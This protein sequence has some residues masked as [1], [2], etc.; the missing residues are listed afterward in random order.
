[1]ARGWWFT[2]SRYPVPW[3]G[4]GGLPLIPLYGVGGL[5]IYYAINHWRR[6]PLLVFLSGF[7]ILTLLELGVSYW[8]TEF[9]GYPLWLYKAPLSF[10]GGRLDLISSLAWG[11][12]AL[13]FVYLIFPPL[14]RLFDKLRRRRWFFPVVGVLALAILFCFLQREV[15]LFSR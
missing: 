8:S 3:S 5:L 15:G 4:Y 9:Y 6:W 14:D 2:P 1:M 11:L 10:W 7:V 12:G 13:L